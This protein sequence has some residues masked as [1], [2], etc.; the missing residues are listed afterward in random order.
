M[1]EGVMMAVTMMSKMMLKTDLCLVLSKPGIVK[2][3]VW[4]LRF[5]LLV[6]VKQTIPA[7]LRQFNKKFKQY[8]LKGKIKVPDF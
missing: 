1:M 4:C 8:F 5:Y 2:G 3:A 7:H 6:L